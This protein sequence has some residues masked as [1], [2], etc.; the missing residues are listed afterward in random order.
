MNPDLAVL[1]IADAY[2][3]PDCNVDKHVVEDEPGLY[4]I[5]VMHDSTCPTY[6]VMSRTP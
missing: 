2:Q 1:A 5:V 4:R 6:R 3:C